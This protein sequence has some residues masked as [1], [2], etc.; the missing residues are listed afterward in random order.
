MAKRKSAS[1][2]VEVGSLERFE[3]VKVHRRELKN[4]EYNPR[5]LSDSARAKLKAGILKHGLVAPQTWNARTGNIVGGHQRTD[6]LDAAYGT[7]DYELTVARIDVDETREKELN[8]LLNNSYAQGDTDLSKLEKLFRETPGIEI[9][10]TGFDSADLFRLFG[11]SPFENRADDA[12]SE[13]ARKVREA[14]EKQA[15]V[16]GAVKE[17]EGTHYYLVVIFE[18]E[19]DRLDFTNAC[20]LPDNRYQD[21]R[22]FRIIAADWIAARAAEAT[23]EAAAEPET[24]PK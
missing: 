22:H 13:V 21:G 7:D 4:A 8:L 10:A 5:V 6:V 11:A 12:L 15:A 1:S 16:R 17:R 18:D 24:P 2:T 23:D 9:A 14:R 20:Q 3:M 19:A